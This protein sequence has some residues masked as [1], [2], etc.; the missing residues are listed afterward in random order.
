MNSIFFL[1]PILIIGIIPLVSALPIAYAD[2]H[3]GTSDDS[4][5]CVIFGFCAPPPIIIHEVTYFAKVDNGNVVNVIVADPEFVGTLDGIWVQTFP[6]G[7]YRKQY[8]GIGYYY[9]W[10]DDVFISPPPSNDAILNMT[11]FDWYLPEPI[12]SVNGT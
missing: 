5:W 7:E 3:D 4:I 1:I 11:S 2:S 9:S 8:A 12:T 10:F 6:N